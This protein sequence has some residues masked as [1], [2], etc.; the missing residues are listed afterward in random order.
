MLRGSYLAAEE[1]A[2]EAR[3][4]LLLLLLLLLLLI[5]LLFF[6]RLRGIKGG[7]QGSERKGT[8]AESSI[9]PGVESGLH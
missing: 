2:E 3:G 4:F 8:L 5:L 1:A 6:S 7:N 9:G